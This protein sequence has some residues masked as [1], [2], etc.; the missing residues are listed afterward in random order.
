MKALVYTGVEELTYR[1]E[2]NPK[3]IAGESIIK[4]LASGICGLSR[5]R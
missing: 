1:E 5:Q 3:E 4:V 2:K